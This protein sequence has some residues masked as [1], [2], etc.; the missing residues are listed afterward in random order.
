MERLHGPNGA[1]SALLTRQQ[2]LRPTH[3]EF[4]PRESLVGHTDVPSPVAGES[5]TSPL[6][7]ILHCVRL[8][9]VWG[10]KCF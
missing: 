9:R 6:S 8:R 1:A 3:E 7:T 5:G 10:G 4:V 2:K